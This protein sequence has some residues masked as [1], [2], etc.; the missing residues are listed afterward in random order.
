M[1]GNA[2]GKRI[3][4]ADQVIAE[5]I[6]ALASGNTLV[7]RFVDAP[8]DNDAFHSG[9]AI[10]IH[11]AGNN[12]DG[13]CIEEQLLVDLGGGAGEVNPFFGEGGHAIGIAFGA[14]FAVGARGVGTEEIAV[15][16]VDESLRHGALFDVIGAEEINDGERVSVLHNAHI[17]GQVKGVTKN[18]ETLPQC[19]GFRQHLNDF[20]EIGMGDIW[21][22]S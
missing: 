22:E 12:N 2:D 16:G 15:P 21:V 9:D 5:D 3:D 11:F 8:A 19:E 13:V 17:K 14:F 10:N 7:G 6:G 4:A 20:A 1:G 18:N